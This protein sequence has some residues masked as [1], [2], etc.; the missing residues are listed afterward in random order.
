M[1]TEARHALL[2]DLEGLTNDQW[3]TVSLCRPWTVHQVLAHLVSPFERNLK[4]A[5]TTLAAE[6]SIDGWFE[7]LAVEMAER[8]SGPE[9]IGKLRAKASD[10]YFPSRLDATSY[11]DVLVHANDIRRVVGISR[12]E[13]PAKVVPALD[14]VARHP[15]GRFSSPPSRR[16]GF[17]FEATDIDWSTGDGALVSGTAINLLMGLTGRT[18][19]TIELSG[20]GADRFK[21]NLPNAS[22]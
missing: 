16:S 22:E 20:A 17:G 18:H 15:M 3:A 13:D 21:A 14:F 2:D 19:P 8:S 6:R 11:N 5:A 4:L 10:R 7:R 9:L 1:T 12:P